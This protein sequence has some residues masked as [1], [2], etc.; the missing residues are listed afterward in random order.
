MPSAGRNHRVEA[1]AQELV[2]ATTAV[3]LRWSTRFVRREGQPNHVIVGA[4][5]RSR[6][7]RAA[8]DMDHVR[9]VRLADLPPTPPRRGCQGHPA[10]ARGARC[11]HQSF[12]RR[13]VR[14]GLGDDGFPT[15]DARQLTAVCGC[16]TGT[17]HVGHVIVTKRRADVARKE[18]RWRPGR[19]PVV[20]ATRRYCAAG[21]PEADD[22]DRGDESRLFGPGFC[23]R[24]PLAATVRTCSE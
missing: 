9:N 24:S 17:V 13:Q 23:R 2:G 8:D 5:D 22:G 6:P 10:G 7:A 18:M 4:D 12:R 21:G 19:T 3:R 11:G 16:F 14:E 15:V 20:A 1:R